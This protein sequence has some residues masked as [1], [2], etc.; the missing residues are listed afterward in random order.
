MDVQKQ[1]KELTLSFFKIINAEINHDA[2]VYTILIPKKYLNYFQKPRIQIT[3]DEKIA[4][5]TNYEL[6]IPGSKT[7]FQIITNCNNRGPISI[8]QSM[9]G[10][11]NHAIRYHFYV[12]FSG[13]KHHSQLSSVTVNLQNMMVIEPT[14][15][16]KEIDFPSNF[17]LI[18]K[19]ITPAFNIALDEMKQKT[20]ELQSS[21]INDANIAFEN[22][23]KLF[24]SK[25]EDEV[26]EL[27]YSITQKDSTL[28]DFEKIKKYRFDTID[29]IEKIE[30]EKNSLVD[31]LQNKHQVNIDYNLVATEILSI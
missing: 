7:L 29:K 3:F 16:L 9:G 18:S 20:F 6:I 13:I 14:T 12:N 11:M 28:D 4:E 15:I 31:T 23:S 8:K 25:Y 1:V 26:R 2:G 5:E 30:K 24:I 27:D 21:F 22:D 19:K 10:G 17:K